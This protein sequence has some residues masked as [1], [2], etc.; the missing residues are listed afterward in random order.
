MVPTYPFSRVGRNLTDNGWKRM[1]RNFE[2]SWCDLRSEFAIEKMDTAK[3]YDLLNGPLDGYLASW[4]RPKAP[5]SEQ[6]ET[7]AEAGN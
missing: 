7:I 2:N 3:W 1:K 4:N 5:R 6:L